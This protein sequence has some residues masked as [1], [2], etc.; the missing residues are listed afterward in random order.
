VAIPNEFIKVHKD[1]KEKL[2]PDLH[3]YAFNTKK[4]GMDFK[5]TKSELERS[6]RAP[7]GEN[8]EESLFTK[9]AL[10]LRKFAKNL[11]EYENSLRKQK[12]EKKV[13]S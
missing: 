3:N 9:K 7:F 1:K 11:K 4:T 12:K 13:L 10:E 2:F 5:R 8:T 6:V